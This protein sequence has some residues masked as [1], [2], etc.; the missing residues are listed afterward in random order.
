M[1]VK[2]LTLM[3]SV[4]KMKT[5]NKII[6]LC[7][8]PVVVIL[9]FIQ[10]Y[11]INHKYPQYKSVLY[12]KSSTVSYN[13]FKINVTGAKILN[14][15]EIKKW[16]HSFYDS[17]KIDGQTM[18][19]VIVNIQIKNTTSSKAVYDVSSICLES[20]YWSNGIVLNGFLALNSSNDSMRPV[21]N[22]REVLS[23]QLPYT[24]IPTQ[25]KKVDWSEV[26]H[27]QF[28]L[29]LSFYPIKRVVLL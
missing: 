9:F 10:Y 11:T 3:K 27:R 23:L 16:N 7:C 17:I 4:I 18:E 1:K 29:V 8:I 6:L 14:D 13:G 25:F 20:N 26:K 19:T 28:N 5:R 15:S 12:E 22:P 21:L 2:L 24:M